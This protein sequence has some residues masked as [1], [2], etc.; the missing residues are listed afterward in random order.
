MLV[1]VCPIAE[2]QEADLSDIHIDKFSTWIKTI[3]VYHKSLFK[4]YWSPSVLFT[5]YLGRILEHSLLTLLAI[6][7]WAGQPISIGFPPALKPPP[8]NKTC[9]ERELDR[10]KEGNK[11]GESGTGALRSPKRE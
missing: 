9:Y 5:V 1:G 8:V 10:S 7:S 2:E 11:G 6:E 3:P 4:Y